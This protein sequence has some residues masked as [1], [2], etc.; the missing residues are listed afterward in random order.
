MTQLT[1]RQSESRDIPAA[2]VD[3]LFDR[4]AAMYGKHWFDLWSDVPMADVKNAWRE[5]L[6]GVTGE[7]IRHGLEHCKTHNKFPPTLPEFV[8][9]CRQFRVDPAHLISLPAPRTEMPDHIREKLAEFK[10]KVR[11]A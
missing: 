2:W 3:R 8:G 5:D 6:A 11:A 4:F 7:Q 10:Q 9:L 1:A